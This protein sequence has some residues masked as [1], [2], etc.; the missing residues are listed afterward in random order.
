MTPEPPHP[1]Q[2]VIVQQ[3]PSNGLGVAGF[4]TSLV[5]LL[6]TC[7]FLSPISLLLSLIGLT[8][9]P[10]GFAIAG[11][12]ISG[13]QLLLI[14]IIGV[15][16]ILALVG[17][18]ISIRE[19]QIELYD[20]NRVEVLETLRTTDKHEDIRKI[21]TDYSLVDDKDLKKAL[22][23]AELRVPAPTSYNLSE[24]PTPTEAQ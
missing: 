8:K 24:E 15:G 9:K 14:L 13:L 2:T 19:D 16:P 18:G 5:S 7:G 12:L 6:F 23:E 11:S 1:Q 17:L 20:K 4:V 3:P 22:R 21:R 10:R